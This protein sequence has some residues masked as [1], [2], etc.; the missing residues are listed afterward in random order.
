MNNE[1]NLLSE[2]QLKESDVLTFRVSAAN[3]TYEHTYKHKN[4]RYFFEKSMK[5][6]T[7]ELLSKL[8]KENG[9]NVSGGNW[10]DGLPCEIIRDGKEIKGKVRIKVAIEF[11]PDEVKVPPN[12]LANERSPLDDIRQINL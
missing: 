7:S 9:V 8:M 1:N 12:S 11:I 6:L 10:I 5:S 4:F 2:N 3:L